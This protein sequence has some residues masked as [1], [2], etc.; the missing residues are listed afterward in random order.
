[1]F[2]GILIE[3]LAFSPI[4]ERTLKIRGLKK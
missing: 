2:V 4:R 3:K 1:M